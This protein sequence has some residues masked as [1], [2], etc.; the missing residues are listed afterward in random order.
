MKLKGINNYL[1]RWIFSY[2][3]NIKRLN[4][5]KYNKKLQGKLEITKYTYQ[6]QLFESIITPALLNDTTILLK[7]KIIDHGKIGIRLEK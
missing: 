7:N 5:I 6:K 4:I 3:N 2:L 1:L